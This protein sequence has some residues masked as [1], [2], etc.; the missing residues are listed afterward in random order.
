MDDHGYGLWTL[1]AINTAIFIVFAFSFFKLRSERDWRA[2]GAFSA[3]VRLNGYVGPGAD[4][5]PDV[6]LRAPERR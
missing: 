2:M 4:R 6:G 3:F 5:G 1:V